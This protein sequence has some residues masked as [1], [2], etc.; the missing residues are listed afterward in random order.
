[1]EDI[2]P[3][4][5]IYENSIYVCA[6]I[7]TDDDSTLIY[8]S[9][10]NG[11]TWSI[12][13]FDAILG[14][15]SAESIAWNGSVFCAIAMDDDGGV[16]ESYT[17]SDGITWTKNDLPTTW[18]ELLNEIGG[19][20]VWDGSVFIFMSDK[21]VMT[22]A[23]GITWSETNPKTNSL[24]LVWGC[25][26]VGGVTIFVGDEGSSTNTAS[27]S[28]DSGATWAYSV[29]ADSGVNTYSGICHNGTKFFILSSYG[30]SAY[31]IVCSST[32]GTSF[33]E[34]S[35]I[36]GFTNTF[37]GDPVAL[38]R[39]AWN[40]SVFCACCPNGFWAISADAITWAVYEES[41]FYFAQIIGVVGGFLATAID[42]R[43]ARIAASINTISAL[44]TVSG[45]SFDFAQSPL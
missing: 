34:I 10:D 42:G 18:V 25:K 14:G 40:G 12:G 15:F 35:T 4:G 13:T 23:D 30:D 39:I 32:D 8:S 24:A 5:L 27:I 21:F 45:T 33:V 22:S 41:G 28:T 6:G 37:I 19:G 36:E 16:A 38:N 1:M 9:I 43:T 26:S 17:S 20:L 11:E 7:S 3:Q 31:P 44:A 29:P 2:S